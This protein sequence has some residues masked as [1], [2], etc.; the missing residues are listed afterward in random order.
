MV[1]KPLPVQLPTNATSGPRLGGIGADPVTRG[2]ARTSPKRKS[3]GKEINALFIVVAFRP[4]GFVSAKAHAFLDYCPRKEAHLTRAQKCF[5]I[6]LAHCAALRYPK[7][8]VRA[9]PSCDLHIEGAW[10]FQ[11]VKR[12]FERAW[13]RPETPFSALRRERAIQGGSRE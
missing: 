5:A 3:L 9:R 10:R 2:D 1:L 4:M 13:S 12:R 8:I 6:P 7:G 11:L